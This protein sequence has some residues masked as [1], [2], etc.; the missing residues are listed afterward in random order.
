MRRHGKQRGSV[1]LCTQRVRVD[2]PR[3]RHKRG[4]A[5]AEVTVRAYEA[6][7]RNGS[8]GEQ[9]CAI[10][11]SGVSTRHSERVVPEL[12]ER[13]GVS[14]SAVSRQFTAASAEQLRALC[15]RRLDALEVLVSYLDGVRFGPHHVVAAI[16]VAAD[17]RKHLL[18][19]GEGATENATVVTGLLED[20][21]ARGVDPARRRRHV[22]VTAR[23]TKLDF[24]EMIREL[25][26][27]HYREAERIVLVMDNLNTHTPGALYEAFA[28]EEARRL[29]ERLE[30]HYTPKHGSWLNIAE[31]ELS[32]LAGQCTDR[33][34]ADE[35][36]L[37]H[38]VAA[39]QRERNAR[40]VTVDWQFTAQNA[41]IKLKRLYPSIHE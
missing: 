14:R 28:P 10:L 4:G 40:Q 36:T 32:A 29:C 34:I 23:R 41:R 35:R 12:A 17:G 3:L 22:H 7:Q 21:V 24:A 26:D 11:M 30:I 39:W 37:Q 1:Q 6:M 38:E 33:R 5:G 15:E 27:V 25:V 2:R 13:C 19:L 20:L 18:G 16:G 8:L 31:C 9:L